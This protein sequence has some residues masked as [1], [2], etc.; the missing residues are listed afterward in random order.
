MALFFSLFRMEICVVCL[1]VVNDS[2]SRSYIF[3]YRSFFRLFV[4]FIIIRQFLIHIHI[5]QSSSPFYFVFCFQTIY[6]FIF[7]YGMKNNAVCRHMHTERRMRV[8]V[9]S[10][11]NVRMLTRKKKNSVE[12]F[13]SQS[14]ITD[15]LSI[16]FFAFFLFSF[17]ILK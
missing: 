2:I 10:F 7:Q 9:L 12:I 14:Q 1:C 5:N 11:V 4:C 3:Q 16:L 6:V 8:F 13:L 17:L 15:T